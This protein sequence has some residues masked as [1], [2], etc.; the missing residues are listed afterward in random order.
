M[1][2]L[3]I[4]KQSMPCPDEASKANYSKIQLVI[5]IVEW[6]QCFTYYIVV[7]KQIQ[8]ERIPDLLGYEHLILQAHKKYTGNRWVVY[9]AASTKLPL[10][11]M[12][13]ER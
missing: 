1:A 5:S 6:A 10:L 12:D 8:P 13:E 4:D 9:T 11:T 7:C 3:T 2:K